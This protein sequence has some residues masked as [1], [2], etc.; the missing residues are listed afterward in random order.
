MP[1]PPRTPTGRHP[2]AATPRTPTPSSRNPYGGQTYAQPSG[3]P[4]GVTFAHW[5]KRVGALLIDGLV[6]LL[7]YVP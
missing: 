5:G 7:A 4:Q 2:R 3:V 1:S 6:G